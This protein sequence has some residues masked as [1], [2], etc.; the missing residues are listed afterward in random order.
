MIASVSLAFVVSCYCDGHETR[1]SSLQYPLAALGGQRTG[2]ATLLAGIVWFLWRCVGAIEHTARRSAPVD[3]VLGR[4]HKQA[5]GYLARVRLRAATRRS[6]LRRHV[7]VSKKP[8]SR[9]WFEMME[10]VSG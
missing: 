1:R 7:F 4:T 5:H 6:S 8:T 9:L 2:H 3:I 10:E